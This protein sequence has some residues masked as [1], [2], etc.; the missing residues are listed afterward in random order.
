MRNWDTPGSTVLRFGLS[1]GPGNT[2]ANMDDSYLRRDSLGVSRKWIVGRQGCNASFKCSLE[3]SVCQLLC[4]R[5]CI[6]IFRNRRRCNIASA[7]LSTMVHRAVAPATPPCLVPAA[8][9]NVS[10]HNCRFSESCLT[11]LCFMQQEQSYRFPAL[12]S[13]D[14]K[15][16]AFRPRPRTGRNVQLQIRNSLAY[17]QGFRQIDRRSRISLLTNVTDRAAHTHA[18]RWH[19]ENKTSINSVSLVL[20]LLGVVSLFGMQAL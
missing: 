11:L 7:F 12:C 14:I 17:A 16:Y 2:H 5:H 18:K 4:H 19:A 13:R 20:N 3:A 9:L 8:G 1:R 6:S 10:A 15:R